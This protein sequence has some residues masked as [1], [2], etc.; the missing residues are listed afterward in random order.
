MTRRERQIPA[1]RLTIVARAENYA[2]ARE[3]PIGVGTIVRLNSGSPSCLVVDVDDDGSL[4]I[5]YQKQDDGRIVEISV[6]CACVHRVR[7]LT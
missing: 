7:D 1:N 6:P 2:D 3:P 4:V 5:G